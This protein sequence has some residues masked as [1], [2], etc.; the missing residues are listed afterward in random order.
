MAAISIHYNE[1]TPEVK[2]VPLARG[3]IVL[4]MDIPG[5]DQLTLFFR[6]FEQVVAV[7]DQLDAAV[8]EVAN[9]LELLPFE[10]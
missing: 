5:G 1:A 10:V 6:N 4:R 8:I 7:R 2:V 3:I 9:G